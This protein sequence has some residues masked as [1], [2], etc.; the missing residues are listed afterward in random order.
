MLK[1]YVKLAYRN[2]IKDKAYSFF[3]IAGLTIGLSAS[4][5]ILLWVQNENSFD[6]F[7]TN[8]NQLYRINTDFC[9][10]KY[11]ANSAGMPAGIK[12]EIPAIK[13][14]VRIGGTDGTYFW[15]TLSRV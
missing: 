14:T 12:A 7:H 13:N 3:N 1:T 4:I 5:L 9:N 6:K 15:R 8:S 2:I 11:A 10:T